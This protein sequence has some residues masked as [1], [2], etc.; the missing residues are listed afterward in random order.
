MRDRNAERILAL[1]ERL[2]RVEAD[3]KMLG[4]FAARVID[5]LK[6]IAPALNNHTQ[7]LEMV[8]LVLEDLGYCFCD[9]CLEELRA[10]TPTPEDMPEDIEHAPNKGMH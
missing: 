6:K 3:V 9:K 1:E 2:D 5:D 10:T 4:N 8:R 7:N